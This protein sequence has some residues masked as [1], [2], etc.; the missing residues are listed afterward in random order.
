[1]AKVTCNDKMV[2]YKKLD[3]IRKDNKDYKDFR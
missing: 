3:Q 1:M 2:D